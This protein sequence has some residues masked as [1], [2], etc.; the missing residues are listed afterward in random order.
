MAYRNLSRNRQRGKESGDWGDIDGCL[1]ERKEERTKLYQLIQ[2]LWKDFP[3]DD[4]SNTNEAVKAFL[5]KNRKFFHQSVNEYTIYDA[6][7]P[8]PVSEPLDP[9]T[10]AKWQKRRLEKEERYRAEL[11]A[12]LKGNK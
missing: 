5:G 2:N 12:K 10:S 6:I 7:T 1:K 3:S 8:P 9:E 4:Y 11:V